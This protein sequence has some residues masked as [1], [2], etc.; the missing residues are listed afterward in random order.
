MTLA[1]ELGGIAGLPPLTARELPL[2]RAT[3]QVGVHIERD[4]RVMNH[5]DPQ[6]K[7]MHA[8]LE[9]WGRETRDRPENGLPAVTLLGR[10]IEQGPGA[11]QPGRPPCDLSPR[12]AVIDA[13]VSRLWAANREAIKLYYQR[14][15]PMEVMARNLGVSSS[16]LK[17][18]LRRSRWLLASWWMEAAFESK[19]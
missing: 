18:R 15:E 17:E 14:W 13:L 8:L 6:T 3:A 11:G 12:S 1:L 9:Q 2:R 19:R 16:Q 4:R 5:M 10:V 7:E